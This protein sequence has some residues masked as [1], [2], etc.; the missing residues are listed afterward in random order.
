MNKICLNLVKQ[1][2]QNNVFRSNQLG[3]ISQVNFCSSTEKKTV[4]LS[5]NPKHKTSPQVTLISGEKIEVVTLD[6]AKKLAERRQMKLVNVVDFDSK[7]KRAVYKLMTG[8]EYLAEDLKARDQRK[9]ARLESI[10][11]EKLLSI[12]SKIDPHDLESKLSKCVK[13]I[14]KLHE[15]RVV[16]TGSPSDLKKTE[17]IVSQI[18]KKMEEYQGRILQ[19][20]SKEG[21]IKFSILPTIKKVKV[22]NI[23][24]P[25]QRQEKNLLEPDKTP[26]VQQIKSLHT[27][28]F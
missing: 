26:L 12:T 21:V 16:V 20:R 18:E 14:E 11:S 7:S 1:T 5:K 19:K 17:E 9:Q 25:Q 6:Q 8:S 4:P 27:N 13:W 2:I 10:K 28:S 3:F 15:I 22:K 24:Q 23:E